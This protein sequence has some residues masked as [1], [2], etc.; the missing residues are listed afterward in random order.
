MKVSD[1]ECYRYVDLEKANNGWATL[2]PIGQVT[3]THAGYILVYID[4]QSIGND[5]WFDNVHLEH[6][7]SQVLEE[8]MYYPFGLTISQDAGVVSTAQP[9]KYNSKELQTEFGLQYYDYGARM[10]NSQIGRWNNIDQTADNRLWLTPYN[11]VQN[12]PIL[13]I[14]PDGNTDDIVFTGTDN[15]EIRIETQGEQ[16]Y[17]YRVPVALGTNRTLDLG[18]KG[19]N[20]N[21]LAYGYT[22]AGNLDVAG[23]GGG[24]FGGEITVAQFSNPNYKN[25]NYVFA[26]YHSSVSLGAQFGTSASAGL[27][28]FVAF[29]TS[30]KDVLPSSFAGKSFAAG[31]SMDIKHIAGGGLSFSTFSSTKD[32]KKDGWKGVSIGLNAGVGEM[33]NTGSLSLQNSTTTLLNGEK[34]TSD[35]SLM[36]KTTNSLAPIQ[37]AFVQY[38][39]QHLKDK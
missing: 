10:Y 8:D 6:Y 19:V 1:P 18:L 2:T 25:Y 36:D 37:S 24:E 16:D 20:P 27:S 35:R 15:K 13:R 30:A 4:N 26:G 12:N 11:F 9:Y 29:N 17:G 14:D 39:L 38:G 31:Y 22:V 32:P 3:V 7:T 33:A 34:K 28:L 23:I 21:N 5:V